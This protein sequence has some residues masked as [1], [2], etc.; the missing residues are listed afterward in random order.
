MRADRETAYQLA[1]FCVRSSVPLPELQ[2]ARH[3]AGD[4]WRF[5]VNRAAPSRRPVDCW[6]HHWY[7]HNGGRCL[8][9]GRTADGYCLRFHRAG[10]FHIAPAL[11]SIACTAAPG[12]ADRTIRHLLLNQVMPLVAARRQLV[13]HASATCGPAGATG[14]VGPSGAGK[15][16]F[17]AALCQ[18]GA[19]LVTDDALMIVRDGASFSAVPTYGEIRLW[20]DSLVHF[21]HALLGEPVTPASLKLRVDGGFRFER[22]LAPLTALCVLDGDTD[23]LGGPTAERLAARE[24]LLSLLPCTFHLDVA[25]SA[26]LEHAFDRLT[27]LVR[28]VPVYRLRFRWTLDEIA[29]VADRWLGG[30]DP[31]RS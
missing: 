6:F 23:Y 29:T 14:F 24:A 8:S 3:D 17:A 11:H 28:H 4:V 22:T 16:T 10:D 9:F 20:P 31:L 25:D 26:H 5:T 7:E 13:L 15:S 2:R 12:V 21:D 19:R 27:M 18:R 1:D 30:L